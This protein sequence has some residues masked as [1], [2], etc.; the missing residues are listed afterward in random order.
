MNGFVYISTNN[1][2]GKRYVGSHN[3]SRKKY[4]GSGVLIKKALKKY[5]NKNFSREILEE[6][7]TIEEAR[8]LEEKYI[9]EYDTLYPNGYNISPKGGLSTYG[10]HSLDT[11]LKIGN[12]LRGKKRTLD[13]RKL[14]SLK[15]RERG[16]NNQKH[17]TENESFTIIKLHLMMNQSASRIAKLLNVDKGRIERFLQSR[18]E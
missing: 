2:N 4:F 5:G 7:E 10:C 15:A 17:F 8:S 12:R 6:C 14:M 9:R 1:I 16:A 13:Q 3:G 11:R 18:N